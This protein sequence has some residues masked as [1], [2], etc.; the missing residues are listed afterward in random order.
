[1]TV[2]EFSFINQKFKA[3]DN[4]LKEKSNSFTDIFTTNNGDFKKF[5]KDATELFKKYQSYK[6]VEELLKENS[7]ATFEEKVSAVNRFAEEINEEFGKTIGV[8]AE[9]LIQ[10]EQAKTT[11]DNIQMDINNQVDEGNRVLTNYRTLISDIQTG[12]LGL[13]RKTVAMVT[14]F[15]VNNYVPN[16][17]ITPVMVKVQQLGDQ[18]Q[19]LGIRLPSFQI[20]TDF[21]DAFNSKLQGDYGSIVATLKD[22]LDFS[23]V[24]SG[25]G[26]FDFDNLFPGF[27]FPSEYANKIKITKGFDKKNLKAWLKANVDFEIAEQ[28]TLM[29]FG[30]FKVTFSNTTFYANM[31]VEVDADGK[32]TKTNQGSLQTDIGME[33][34]G[35]K[36]MTFKQTIISFVNDRYNFDLD[37]SRMEMSGL[38]KLV[39]DATKN[40]KVAQ[41]GNG[42]KTSGSENA[43]SSF[44]VNVLKEMVKL[45]DGIEL[46]IPYGMEALFNI[47]V[48]QIGGGTSS[49]INLNFGAAFLMKVFNFETKQLDFNLALRFYMSSK[50]APFNFAAFIFG[51]GGYIDCLFDYTPAKTNNGLSVAF[52]MSIQATA[53]LA[54]NAGWIK[55]YVMLGMGIE[56]VYKKLAE[57]DTATTSI[58]MFVQMIGCVIIIDL[59]DIYLM[60]R[61]ETT[62]D[63]YRM[64]GRGMISVE[65]EICWLVSITV[66]R[67]YEKV[68]TGSNQTNT[69]EKKRRTIKIANQSI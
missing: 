24:L 52:A 53:S 66:V 20:D 26:G 67:E 5:K 58:T 41:S 34:Q 65:I 15:D 6:K 17:T 21:L 45:P 49:L 43:E 10:A 50:A 18:L 32:I 39:T 44:S 19:A 48:P 25:I 57:Q 11:F 16:F 23:K 29:S 22:K 30:L 64:I 62:Y 63:G 7:K 37:P 12:G 31:N 60:L 38:L 27:K 56:V 13:N 59:V 40:I 61:L 2:N 68:M 1:M 33:V 47:A 8:Y 46:E 55:G 4:W 28:K 36:L 42:K 3:F 69:T 54:F 35:Q 9:K 51:G 14:N